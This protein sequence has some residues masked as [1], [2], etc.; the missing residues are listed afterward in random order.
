MKYRKILYDVIKYMPLWR[1]KER[2]RPPVSTKMSFNETT[3]SQKDL[4]ELELSAEQSL[5][6]EKTVRKQKRKTRIIL[7]LLFLL[8][9]AAVVIYTAVHE[10]SNKPPEKL[11]FVFGWKNYAFIAA[12]FLCMTLTL[13]I[14]TVKYIL[15]MKALGGKVSVKAAFETAALG[16]C[17]DNITPSGI[18]GQPF[19]I[20]NIH[21]HGYS[22]GISAA[23][24][25]TAFLMMQFGFVFLAILVF[26]FK[27]DAVTT[28]AI[29]IPAYIGA[30]TYSLLPI[31]IV[32][33]T[34]SERAGSFLLD[35]IIR[36]GAKI[37]IIRKPEKISGSLMKTLKDYRASI[38]MISRKRGL[39]PLLF[40][41]S[42]AFQVATCSIPY[43]VL[44]AFNG[45]AP[46]LDVLAMTVFVYCSITFIPTPGNSG[47]AEGSFYI[48]FSQLDP[49]GLFWSMLIWRVICYYSYIAIGFAIYGAMGIR[50]WARKKKEEALHHGEN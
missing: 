5:S 3:D 18:G 13:V 28:L 37:R 47:A 32:I 31:G 14:E 35:K 1:N 38:L 49:T 22:A 43:F 17:Y 4:E 39:L 23:M 11:G 40:V 34:V 44:R 25:L 12:G 48:V 20:Y 27:G 42:F 9:V 7:F 50:S 15:M 41:L 10:F 46:F 6:E 21:R 45:T 36:F 26:L 30:V 8:F 2:S 29:R 33:F 16:K 24:P 19:Q